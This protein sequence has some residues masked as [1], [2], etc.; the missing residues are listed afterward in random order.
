MTSEVR[1]EG[2]TLAVE[3]VS[4]SV[5]FYGNKLGLVVEANRPPNFAMIRNRILFLQ[6]S[7]AARR[8]SGIAS[9]HRRSSFTKTR[10]G[11]TKPV[12]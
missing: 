5:E 12:I 3:D 4:R 11:S 8:L 9:L 2:F 10:G 7:A 1:L 6:Q